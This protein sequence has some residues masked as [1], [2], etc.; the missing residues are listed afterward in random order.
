MA[1]W[2]VTRGDFARATPPR[3]QSMQVAASLPTVT[4]ARSISGDHGLL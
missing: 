4:I 1:M 2:A 3:R